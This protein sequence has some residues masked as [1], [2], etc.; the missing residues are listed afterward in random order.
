MAATVAATPILLSLLVATTAATDTADTMNALATDFCRLDIYYNAIQTEL[1]GWITAASSTA[2]ALEK[3]ARQMQLAAEIYRGFKKGAAYYVLAVVS[4]QSADSAAKTAKDAAA[5]ILP[6]VQLITAR[7]A[8]AATLQFFEETAALKPAKHTPAATGRTVVPQTASNT[9]ICTA[10][11]QPESKLV[12][13]CS[14][15]EGAKAR[16]TK[17]RQHLDKLQIIQTVKT[18]A[19]KLPKIQITAEAQ[20]TF[21]NANQWE[22]T[23]DNKACE[24][25]TRGTGSGSAAAGQATNALAVAAVKLVSQITRAALDITTE[26]GQP[27]SETQEGTGKTSDR[28]LLTADSALAAPLQ[29]AITAKPTQFKRLADWTISDAAKSQAAQAFYKFASKPQAK[30]TDSAATEQIPEAIFGKKE[31][32]IKDEFLDPLTRD[33]RIISTENGKIES[34]TEKLS[35]SNFARAMAYYYSENIKKAAATAGGNPKADGQAAAGA[36]KTEEKKDGDNKAIKSNCSSN[37]TTE[38]F[39]KRQICKLENNA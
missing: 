9:R 19:M 35:E 39:T 8:E 34:S 22:P 5:N 20:G 26:G 30:E 2:V 13:D 38:A 6:A 10:E 21:N 14:S 27:N 1:A 17:I 15:A 25:H 16:I 29:A 24:E 18:T 37:A 31:G 33:T 7:R 4:S 36:D 23:K 32:N 11:V 12:K 28:R 3:E